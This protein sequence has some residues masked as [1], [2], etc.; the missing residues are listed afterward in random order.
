MSSTDPHSRLVIR[1]VAILDATGREPSGRSDVLV[2]SGRISSLDLAGAG[3]GLMPWGTHLTKPSSMS[4][5][6]GIDGC[7]QWP[8]ESHGHDSGDHRPIDA[9]WA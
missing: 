2:E 4:C 9:E 7:S 8:I 3:I 6:C 1:D 5:P